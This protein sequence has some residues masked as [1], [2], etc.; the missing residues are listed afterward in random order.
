MKLDKT[1]NPIPEI[2]ILGRVK[3]IIKKESKKNNGKKFLRE[4]NRRSGKKACPELTK[5]EEERRGNKNKYEYNHKK[6]KKVEAYAPPEKKLKGEKKGEKGRI[7]D[8][9]I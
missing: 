7:I 6:L 9:K 4:L 3:N 2:S 1:Q 8:I 5:E